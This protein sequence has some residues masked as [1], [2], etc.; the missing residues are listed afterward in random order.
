MAASMFIVRELL[1]QSIR[2]EGVLIGC[3]VTGVSVYW[4][5]SH[6]LNREQFYEIVGML[7]FSGD[8]DDR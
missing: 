2:V 3:V 1:R 8:R 4:A 5:A 7:K 6:W